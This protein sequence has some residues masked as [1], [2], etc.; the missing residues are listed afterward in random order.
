MASQILGPVSAASIEV[1]MIVQNTAADGLT[2]V[3]FTVHRA[4]YDRALAIL[5]GVGRPTPFVA[6]DCPTCRDDWEGVLTRAARG[7]PWRRGREASCSS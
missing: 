4:D 2:D 5:A 1:D 7:W 6:T 3:T